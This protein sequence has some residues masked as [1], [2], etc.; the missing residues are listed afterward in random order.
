MTWKIIR[1]TIG[2]LIGMALVM[3]MLALVVLA[4]QGCVLPT[5]PETGKIRIT[6]IMPE[7]TTAVVSKEKREKE[8]L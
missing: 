1:D 4:L 5:E 3:G 6:I 2:S 8:E 7:D